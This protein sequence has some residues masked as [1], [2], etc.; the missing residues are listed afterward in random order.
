MKKYLFLIIVLFICSALFS[1]TATPPSV[2]NGTTSNPYQIET[3][4][5]LYWLSQNVWSWSKHYIQTANIDAA[6]TASWDGGN[7]FS[8]IGNSSTKFT[9]SYDG[10]GHTINHLA[11]NRS[12]EDYIGLFGY[13]ESA[14]ISNL[15]IVDCSIIGRLRAGGLVGSGLYPVISNCFTTGNVS[16][17]DEQCGGLVGYDW[18]GTFSYCYS[19]ATVSGT[20]MIGGFIGAAMK[21]SSFTNCYSTGSVPSGTDVGG[22]V[23]F[24]FPTATADNCFWDTESSG[25]TTSNLGTGKTT[26]EMKMQSTYTGWDFANNWS[27]QDDFNDG[28]PY[29]KWQPVP[30]VYPMPVSDWAIYFGIILIGAFIALSLRK[31]LVA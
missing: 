9:G 18:E 3:L 2:G 26:S 28:Y 20:L 17:T 30:S 11:I 14:S 12:T 22:F 29:L 5:N 24:A 1:Q 8:P 23:G 7:G 10:Q 4:D 13:V 15:G 27:I 25:K 16:V 19:K 31:R 21:L 6:A